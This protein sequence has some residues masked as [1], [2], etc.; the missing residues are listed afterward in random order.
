[1]DATGGKEVIQV[2][3]FIL[4][5]LQEQAV[6]NVRKAYAGGARRVL[7]VGPTGNGKTI[8]SLAVESL[9]LD[10][11]SRVG[12]ITSGRQLIL[13]KAEKAERAGLAFSVLMND[14]GHDDFDCG[15]DLQ[16]VSKDTLEARLGKILFSYPKLWVVDEC[17][18][19]LSPVWRKILDESEFVLGMTATPVNG[20]D[21]GLGDFYDA[22]VEVASYSQLIAS[23]RLVDVPEGKLFSPY[24][25]YLVGMKTSAGDYNT[26]SLTSRMNTPQIV[27]DVVDEWKKHGED[28]RT[29]AFCINKEHTAHVCDRFNAAGINAEFIVDETSQ[30]RRTEIF[31]DTIAGRN[32]VIVNCAVLTRGWDMPE[33]SCGILVNPTK[34]M[35][36]YLQCVG[37]ILRGGVPGKTD[38]VLI[39]HS[40]NVWRHGWPTED[41][42]WSLDERQSQEE[43]QDGAENSKQ[44]ESFCKR[45]G[46][47][48]RTGKVCPNPE[49]GATRGAVTK[50]QAAETVEGKLV[51][52]TRKGVKEKKPVEDDPQKYWTS[53]L[54]AFGQSN[55]THAQASAAFKSK[56]GNWPDKAG[57]QPTCRFHEKDMRISKLWPQF[58]R[59]SKK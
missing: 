24:R 25:P 4:D 12:F 22:I 40:G 30:E 43:L 41:R 9:S 1:M 37:R 34:R 10:R 59:K 31:Q 27:G 48:W 45:C 54:Y 16:I 55:R 49:C 5:E 47:I 11:G 44:P 50:G 51:A 56:T 15:A 20:K 17:D 32:K 36:K 46:A 57:V 14:S 23:G 13:Q 21:K 8:M 58:A 33:I 2:G 7:L 26:A 38:A 29:V 39:D 53:L 19:A 18:V 52:V 3:E 28:R 42:I 6:L 35:R